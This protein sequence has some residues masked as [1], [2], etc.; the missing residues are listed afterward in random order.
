MRKYTK[1]S[2]PFILNFKVNKEYLYP[3]DKDY[4]YTL[5]RIHDDLF[6]V[7]W[8]E[9]GIRKGK[10]Y[11]MNEVLEY[12]NDHSWLVEFVDYQPTESEL[13]D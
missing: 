9:N 8:Y 4:I 11:R 2:L 5:L 10:Q 3:D 1:D 7:H 12:L 13:E 6:V